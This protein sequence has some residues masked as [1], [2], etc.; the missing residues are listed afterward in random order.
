MEEMHLANSN[1]AIEH[2]L[3][4]MEGLST[5]RPSIVQLLLENCTS[6]KAKRLFLWS[7]ERVQH[8]WIHQLDVGR[9][10]LGK[11]KRQLF[12]GGPLHSKYMITVPPE[13]ELPYV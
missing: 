1:S 2:T 3:L 6:I 8:T 4:L 11:G 12:K 7:A 10:D 5:L 9:V 13:E